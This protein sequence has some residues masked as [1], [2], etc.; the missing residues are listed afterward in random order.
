MKI[1]YPDNPVSETLSLFSDSYLVS[2]YADINK[3]DISA[4][5]LHFQA[6]TELDKTEKIKEYVDKLNLEIV[7]HMP[8]LEIDGKE[9]NH[10]LP[11]KVSGIEHCKKAEEEDL[12]KAIKLCSELKI[13]FLTMHASTARIFLTDEEFDIFK[14]KIR[15]LNDFAEENNVKLSIETG[16][17]KIKQLEELMEIGLFI[18]LDTAHLVLDLIEQDVEKPNEAAFDFFR[19]NQDKIHVL[20]LSQTI[21]GKDSHLNINEQG[22][23]TINKKLID[24]SKDLD[25]T[26]IFEFKSKDL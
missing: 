4:V 12:R 14:D 26:I 9:F 1:G 11:V 25:K 8:F 5:E 17:L 6:F 20:H 18:T 24:Y 10:L 21:S 13:K 2:A 19:E 15:I 3:F 23:I 7:M 16:G 22:I